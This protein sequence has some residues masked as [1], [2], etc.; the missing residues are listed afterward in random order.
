MTMAIHTQPRSSHFARAGS[1]ARSRAPR[2]LGIGALA[3]AALG[4]CGLT[5]EPAQELESEQAALAEQ[6]SP[7]A[8]GIGDILYPGLGNGGYDVDHYDLALRYETA[9][10]SQAIEG[11]VTIWARA[12]QSLSQLNLD[13]AGDAVGGVSVDGAAAAYAWDGEELVITP[14]RPIKRG[15]RFAVTVSRFAASPA[16]PDP[17]AFLDAPFFTTP[18]GTAWAGQPHNAHRIFP[19]NDHPRDKASF[20]FRIDV[21]AGTTAVANGELAA[22]PAAG[23][24]AIWRYEQREPMATE[25]AQVAVGAFTVTDRGRHRGVR[26][27][28]VTPARLTAGLAPKL[29]AELGHLDWL[30]ERLGDYPFGTY[31]SLVVDTSLGF[32]LETQTL[33]LYEAAFFDQPAPYWDSVM[34]HELAHQWF[35]NSVAPTQWSDVWQNEGHAT[36]YEIS[37]MAD[38]D[39]P[40]FT[41]FAQLVYSLGD[42]WRA[43]LGPVAAPYSGDPEWLFNANVY[44]G[45][46][47][48]LYALRQEVGDA[49]FRATE[50]T[51]VAK[52]RGRS[53]S[54]ADFIVVASEVSGRDLTAFL[55]AWLYG[56]TTPPMPG[57]PDWTV[58]PVDPQL[59][60]QLAADARLAPAQVPMKGLRPIMRH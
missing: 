9:S 15:K 34:V 32:A 51:W 19:S 47:L 23:G 1:H 14:A 60:A 53:A 28:D 30:R 56:T 11:T 37:S 21:P 54:T 48:V 57:H 24:R 12:T 43:Y 46:A 16:A 20:S 59:A 3:T 35:G 45:G 22:Q 13:F 8:P 5:D 42:L 52:Y 50:R 38:P 18:D 29:G 6:P 4:A 36:W 10:P 7:G 41:G 25:L 58:D 26:V 49:T 31:G 40:A 33:S 44:Y 55:E 17:D 27:R 2:A 39:S